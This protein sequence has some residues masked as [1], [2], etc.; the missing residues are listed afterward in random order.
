MVETARTEPLLWT[1]DLSALK[2]FYERLGFETRNVW[3]PDGVLRWCL[4]EFRGAF[5]MLQQDTKERNE[6]AVSERKRDY[7]LYFVCDGDIDALYKTL[8]ERGVSA[9]KPR[10]EFYGMRQIF[11]RDPDGRN[12]CFEAPVEIDSST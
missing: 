8:Q 2:A 11:V 6:K 9:T 12:V 7:G 10:T 3:E 1:S 5:L 4:I